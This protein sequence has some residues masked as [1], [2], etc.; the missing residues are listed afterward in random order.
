[1]T[2]AIIAGPPAPELPFKFVGGD[3]AVD[4]VNTVDWAGAALIDDRLSDYERLTEWAEG[5][6]LLMPKQGV[7]FRLLAKEHP[8]L[9]ARAHECALRLRWN[10]RQ[11]FLAIAEG[12]SLT[13]QPALAELNESIATTFA[14]LQLAPT[15]RPESDEG[16]LHWGWR[17]ATERLDSVLWPVV[18]SGVELLASDEATRVRQ[19]GAP[20]CG[21]M[22][23]DRSRNGL[24]RWCQMEVCGTQEKSRKRAARRGES[25]R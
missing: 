3:P 15:S 8:T 13:R 20:A 18:R 25:D 16:P 4:L 24:R 17:D 21:W 14:Q 11:L 2:P 23:V 10:L 6:G 22:F 12:R 1:M 7:R 5:A 19:C 9:A